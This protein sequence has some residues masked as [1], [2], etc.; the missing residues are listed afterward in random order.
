MSNAVD[1]D[2][3]VIMLGH[4]INLNKIM[5]II[6]GNG[7]RRLLFGH[8]NLRGG[9]LMVNKDKRV[10]WELTIGDNRPDVMVLSETKIG[11]NE[12]GLC[13]IKGYTWETKDDS[14]RISVMVNNSLDYRRRADLEVDNMVVIWVDV[15]T[16]RLD[17]SEEVEVAQTR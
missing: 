2:T 1:E 17:F 14:P 16:R 12:N 9:S 3:M 6:N 4:V 11:S 15:G 13:N 10:Q 5:R 8:Q 7:R